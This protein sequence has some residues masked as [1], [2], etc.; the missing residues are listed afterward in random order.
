MKDKENENVT[1][2]QRKQKWRNKR[3]VLCIAH[4][5]IACT[6]NDQYSQLKKMDE[7]WVIHSN[8]NESKF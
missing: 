3:C 4:K 6:H 8:A 2:H 5:S 1:V 7:I